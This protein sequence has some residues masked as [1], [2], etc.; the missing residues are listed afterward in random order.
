MPAYSNLFMCIESV[1]KVGLSCFLRLFCLKKEEKTGFE[2]F[3][4]FKYVSL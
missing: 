1:S 3:S 2:R 4:N